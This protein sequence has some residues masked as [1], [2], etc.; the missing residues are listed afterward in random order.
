MNGRVAFAPSQR[1]A[2][3]HRTAGTQHA[4]GATS[5]HNHRTAAGH[6]H[7]T[8]LAALRPELVLDEGRGRLPLGVVPLQEHLQRERDWQS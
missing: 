2:P 1:L 3:H 5:H 6:T 4:H 7:N 8:H